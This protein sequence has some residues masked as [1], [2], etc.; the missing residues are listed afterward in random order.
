MNNTSQKSERSHHSAA[1]LKPKAIQALGWGGGGAQVRDGQPWWDVDHKHITHF[2]FK[3]D[4][5]WLKGC[6]AH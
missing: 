2:S 1:N 5:A 3:T 4:S 6:A